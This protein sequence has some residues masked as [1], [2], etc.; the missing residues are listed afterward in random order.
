MITHLMITRYKK[1][2]KIKKSKN[3]KNV[4]DPPLVNF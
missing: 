1:L 4:K 2:D 3:Q